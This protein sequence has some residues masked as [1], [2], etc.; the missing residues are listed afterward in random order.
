[1]METKTEPG[2]E[3]APAI[4]PM[5]ML[6][7]AVEQNA[8]LDKMTKLMDLQERWEANEAKKAFVVAINAFKADPP[9][10]T[11]D[12]HVDFSTSKG[13]TEYDHAT[14]D[15][16][17][18]VIGEALSKHGISHRWETSQTNGAIGVTCV[19]THELGHSERVSLE[20]QPDASGGKNAIQ[21]IG[22]TVTYLQRY[23]LLAATGIAVQNGDD[24]GAGTSAPIDANQKEHIV[25]LLKSTN[26]DTPKFLKYMKV[27]SVDEIPTGQFHR[28]IEALNAKK[29]EQHEKA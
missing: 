14:L 5:Q 7:I 15:Q 16:V 6:Q 27:D 20:S 10:L 18:T 8:D 9:K 13:R 2:T 28:A 23:T 3:L 11:R 26:A 22:S 1:M 24:D 17:S 19:L 4:T 25:G 21:A 29:R 12:K